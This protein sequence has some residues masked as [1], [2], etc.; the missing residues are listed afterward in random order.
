MYRHGAGWP[1][2]LDHRSVVKCVGD[3][4]PTC[5]YEASEGAQDVCTEQCKMEPV[6]LKLRF[7][8]FIT[9]AALQSS[10]TFVH[11]VLRLGQAFPP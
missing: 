5:A 10:T 6:V 8:S 2:L 1:I 11:K 9:S 4:M 3:R 7:C